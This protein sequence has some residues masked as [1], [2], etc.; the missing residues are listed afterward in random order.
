MAVKEKREGVDSQEVAI[1]EIDGV[2][3]FDDR[4]I[5]FSGVGQN[6]DGV[7]MVC[8][9]YYKCCKCTNILKIKCVCYYIRKILIHFL[10]DTS[11]L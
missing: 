5:D 8:V 11:L 9:Q 4:P 3:L 10:I 7:P 1:S 2:P 6:I